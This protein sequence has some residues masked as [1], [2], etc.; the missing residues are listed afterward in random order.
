MFNEYG[1]RLDR[2]GYAPSIVQSDTHRCYLCGKTTGKLDRHEIFGASNRRKSKAYGLW[3]M[4]C[5]Y[6]C[7]EGAWGV[8]QNADVA[9]KM[10]RIGQ[11]AAM[12][13]YGWTREDFIQHFGK[14]YLEG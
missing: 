5:H 3:V 8:H 7:H 9:L 14:N 4:L 6:S 10:R 12:E 11:T 1:E 2:N 13:A